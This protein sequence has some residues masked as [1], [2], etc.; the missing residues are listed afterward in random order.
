M[1]V[2]VKCYAH[3]KISGVVIVVKPNL[4]VK[5]HARGIQRRSAQDHYPRPMIIALV[6]NWFTFVRNRFYPRRKGFTL[7][8]ELFCP[9]T[10]AILL[11]RCVR[12]GAGKCRA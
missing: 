7:V 1:L 10:L 8:G 4:I 6:K 11:D 2:L 12:T 5:V 3:H 9:Q